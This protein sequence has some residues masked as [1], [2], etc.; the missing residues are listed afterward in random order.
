[1]LIF[2][3]TC[4]KE[5]EIQKNTILPMRRVTVIPKIFTSSVYFG[6][7]RQQRFGHTGSLFVSLKSASRQLM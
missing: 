2:S 5:C 4:N 3:T 1:M 6:V 7:W